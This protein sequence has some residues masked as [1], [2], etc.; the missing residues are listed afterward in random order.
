ML[1]RRDFL[2]GAVGGVGAFCLFNP[3]SLAARQGISEHSGDSQN[4]EVGVL[5]PSYLETIVCCFDNPKLKRM[6]EHLAKEI[7][8]DVRYYD[9]G[10]GWFAIEAWSS[11]FIAIVDR[12]LIDRAAWDE[13][14]MLCE[15]A[16]AWKPD[17]N[18]E[19]LQ[20]ILEDLPEANPV[21]VVDS[22][23]WPTNKY[24]CPIN[25]K[26]RGAIDKI[27]QLIMKTKIQAVEEHRKSL[28]KLARRGRVRLYAHSDEP[29]RINE[30]SPQLEL[31][32]NKFYI[33]ET[34]PA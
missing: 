9:Y 34:D 4:Q 27:R 33:R 6:I 10:N 21:V 30:P 19:E 11:G 1:K 22:L 13:Y 23:N 2:K 3:L 25:P 31:K 32:G 12:N 17:P 7:N 5:N 29:V 18:D 15:E 26:S 24:V 20:R 8:C 16:E 14:I 28:T